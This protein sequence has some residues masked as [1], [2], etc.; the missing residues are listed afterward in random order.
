MTPVGSGS[1][2]TA[3]GW[4]ALVDNITDL[5]NR[6]TTLTS[7]V[8]RSDGGTGNGSNVNMLTIN[9]NLTGKTGKWIHVYGGTAIAEA[10]NTANTSIIRLILD[11]NAGQTTTIS[12]LRQGIGVYSNVAWDGNSTASLSTQ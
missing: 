8:V 10:S 6:V 4:N 7:N 12:T 3:N 9:V 1:G 2:L 5:N 11:N